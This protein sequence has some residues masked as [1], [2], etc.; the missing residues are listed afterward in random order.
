MGRTEFWPCPE[1]Y[2]SPRAAPIGQ[3]AD[4]AGP[5]CKR[6]L[7]FRE[8]PI[9]S[10]AV[11]RTNTTRL[12][13]L[14]QR[15]SLVLQT[16]ACLRAGIAS[17]R[18]R[19]W[20]PAER[21]LARELSVGRNTLRL[22]LVE[23]GRARL[24]RTERNRGHRITSRPGNR[25]AATAPTVGLILPHA[26]GL[27]RPTTIQ[28][29]DRLRE[30]LT[31]QGGRLQVHC[32]PSCYG[33]R[34]AQ[35]L[36]RLC[37]RQPAACWIPVLSSEPMQAWF[38]AEA[39]PCVIA[40]T[41]F[42]GIDLP[43]VDIDY[44]AI[45]R[46]AAGMLIA[47]GHRRLAIL[48][49][50]VRSAGDLETAAGFLAATRESSRPAEASILHTEDNREG[51]VRAIAAALRR[52]EAPTGLLVANPHRLI[53]ITSWLST[54]PRCASG[55]AAI[56]RDDDPFLNFLTPRPPRYRFDPEVFARNVGKSVTQVLR[57]GLPA[58]RRVRL[59]PRFDHGD[60][61][62]RADT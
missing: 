58:Q 22:A 61:V 20:L 48:L 54:Q 17:G 51:A 52:R 16:A 40:G 26:F 7:P 39:R 57:E 28:W 18:W 30:Q 59:L 36:S 37:V 24:V 19:E 43:S 27:L 6:R 15:Q 38:A 56:S 9:E 1:E 4:R 23:L 44:G 42:E 5:E 2:P 29:I 60:G 31:D 25:Q 11:D 49:K 50:P 13:F 12:S 21:V 8:K 41:N 62:V 14:P 10:Q 45:G 35:A 3:P 53:A 46:H 34:P 55:I 32:A 33:P 47:H